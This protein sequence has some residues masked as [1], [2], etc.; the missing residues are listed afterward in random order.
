MSKFELSAE[1]EAR[2]GRIGQ[3]KEKPLTKYVEEQE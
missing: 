1:E 2:A 3:G